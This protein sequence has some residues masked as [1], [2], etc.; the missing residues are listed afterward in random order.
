MVYDKT[1]LER[2]LKEEL[3]R[4]FTC[5]RKRSD[6]VPIESV[7]GGDMCEAC[8]VHMKIRL[9]EKY[10]KSTYKDFGYETFLLTDC[11]D[12]S[13]GRY[14]SQIGERKGD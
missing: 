2:E 6:C 5:K 7:A 3:D 12:V 10:L 8:D 14:A 1:A 11:C 4:Q 13:S 9:G